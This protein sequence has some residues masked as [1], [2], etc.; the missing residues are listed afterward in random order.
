MK[1]LIRSMALMLA[2]AMAAFALLACAGCAGGVSPADPDDPKGTDAAPEATE[3]AVEGPGSL[4]EAQLGSIRRIA[5][6]L[7]VFGECDIMEGVRLD[8]IEYMVYC[9]YR[10]EP[11]GERDEQGYL[12]IAQADADELITD[13]FRGISIS[14]MRHTNRD[15]ESEQEFFFEDGYYY[16]RPADEVPSVSINSVRPLESEAGK[17]IGVIANVSVTDAE[18]TPEELLL[19]LPFCGDDG[20]SI[21][22]CSVMLLS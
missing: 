13:L 15:P 22:S 17:T 1:K 12:R 21:L 19:E 7:S 20:F 11:S 16:V 5:E 8:R 18:G 4:S 6:A 2:L 9:W 10:F 14:G 3:A